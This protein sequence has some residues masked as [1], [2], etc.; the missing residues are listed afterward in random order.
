M[1]PTSGFL[2][3]AFLCAGLCAAAE[4][5]SDEAQ[6]AAGD[7]KSAVNAAK[8]TYGQELARAKAA[9]DEK[10]EGATD[11]I[12]KEA[13]RKESELLTEELVR[14]QDEVKSETEAGEPKD[15]KTEA[16]RKAK[17]E[18]QAALKAAKAT[19]GQDLQRAQRAILAKKAASADPALKGAFQHEADL[20]AEEL[21]QV[22]EEIKSGKPIRPPAD[23]L[24]KTNVRLQP[25]GKVKT[26]TE[27]FVITGEA[28]DRLCTAQMIAVPFKA[29]IVAKTDST[30]IR[31][32]Y[33]R[34]RIIFNWEM[35][36][37]ELR[38]DNFGDGNLSAHGGQG[39]VPANQWVTIDLVVGETTTEVLVDGQ[40][41]MKIAD[42]CKG[43]KSRLGI[44]ASLG[45]TVTVKTVAVLPLEAKPGA[46]EP[47]PAHG[48]AK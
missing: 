12:A 11:S 21:K 46:G 17:A 27:G 3:M 15:L 22:R 16:A 41:R 33:G 26:T 13:L 28:D 19:Y 4:F 34:G 40:T 10:R 18:H 43:V 6:E 42:D 9:L 35:K 25:Q 24:D 47:K 23:L 36:Q 1:K 2:W 30:N 14:L 38:F 7:Y 8:M 5:K 37:G 45:S 29:R 20:I 32:Y 48:V 31:I 39:K 44:S